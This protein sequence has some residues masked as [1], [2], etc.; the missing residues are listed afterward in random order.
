MSLATETVFLCVLV[1]GNGLVAAA[2]TAVLSSR[3]TV[4]RHA[5]AQNVRGA[6]HA[7]RLAEH[8]NRFLSLVQ[9]WLTL[10]GILAGVLAGARVAPD[11]IALLVQR[12]APEAWVA[13]LAYALIIAVLSAVILI[14]GELIPRRLAAS[15]PERVAALLAGLMRVLAWLA[16]PLLK[17]SRNVT[18]GVARLVGAKPRAAEAAGDEEVRALVEKGMH[19]G[20]LHRAEKEMVEGVLALDQLRVTAIM[21]PR[22]KIVFLNIDDS[23]EA[24]W[25]KIV[26]S[27]H[28]YFPVYQGHRDQVVGF[29]AVKALWANS[30]IGASTALKNLLSPHLAV[31]ERLTVIQ[32]LEQFKQSG[33]HIAIVVDE[34]GAVQGLVTLIDVF[35]AIAGDIPE[36]R[37]AA[38]PGARKRGEDKWLIDAGLA[39]DELKALMGI[40]HALPQ[41]EEVGYKTLSGFI[42]AQL[43]HIPIEGETFVYGPWKFEIIDMDRH[44]ID[45]VLL[46]RQPPDAARS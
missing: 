6:A 41:E 29:V 46:T 13:P 40:E 12:G 45:K 35:E 17:V 14:C 37:R 39:V 31:P 11:L 9:F 27:G 18:E 36:S 19:A 26:T 20:V 2:E 32:L 16:S 4:L 34:F 5:A 38:G 3:K 44:R 42:T 24:N 23:E 43:G 33:R 22:P 15:N 10:S 8:P 1:I 7:L 30:A 28:S 21:T 25:R